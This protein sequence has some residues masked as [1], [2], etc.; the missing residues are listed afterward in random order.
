[1]PLVVLRLPPL[2]RKIFR[3]LW[4]FLFQ[5]KLLI[6]LYIFL[7]DMMSF[8]WL[9]LF[10][11]DLFFICSLRSFI[12][13]KYAN[14]NGKDSNY[15]NAIDISITEG[16]VGGAVGW[17]GVSVGGTGSFI[18]ALL[19]SPLPFFTSLKILSFSLF[20]KFSLPLRAASIRFGYFVTFCDVLPMFIFRYKEKS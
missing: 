17:S 6:L 16:G 1:M 7:M 18:A 13:K 8:W 12:C 9:I 15:T 10:F 14:A 3:W 2:V 19:V 11:I 5:S 4:L 20:I